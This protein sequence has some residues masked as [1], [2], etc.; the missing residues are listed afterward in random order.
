MR[1]LGHTELSLLKLDVEGAEYE[2]L[3]SILNGHI[4]PAI[5]CVEFDEGYRPVDEAYLARIH[6]MV[7]RIK[8]QGYRLTYVDGWNATFVHDRPMAW[9]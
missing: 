7:G 8:V 9:S 4:R 5:L 6:D 2:I 3:R 1:T